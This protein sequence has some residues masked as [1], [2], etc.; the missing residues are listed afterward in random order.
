MVIR[1]KHNMR[2]VR[3]QLNTVLDGRRN[4]QYKIIKDILIDTFRKIVEISPVDT[5]LYRASH[6]VVYGDFKGI[7]SKNVLTKHLAKNFQANF[8]EANKKFE[9]VKAPKVPVSVSFTATKVRQKINIINPV[10]YAWRL[11]TDRR[12]PQA[13]AGIYRPARAYA[14]S[15]LNKRL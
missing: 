8:E 4:S 12:S 14:I 7:K 6:L 15:L 2:L 3:K 9:L 5:G 1:A 11:E 13:P 10:I